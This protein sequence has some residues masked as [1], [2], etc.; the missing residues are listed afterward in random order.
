MRAIISE[1][2]PKPQETFI[3]THARS[4]NTWNIQL[5]KADSDT[6][7]QEFQAFSRRLVT[8]RARNRY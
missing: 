8:L 3:E 5:Y 4:I 7:D 6:D 2:V 1:M